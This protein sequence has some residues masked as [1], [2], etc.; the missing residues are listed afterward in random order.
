ML[1]LIFISSGLFLGWSLGA[2]DAANIF[3][4]AVGSRMLSFRRAAIIASTF[5]ILGAVF[6]GKGGAETLNELGTVDALGGSFTVTLC[7]AF[8]VYV[9]TKRRL[10]VSTSQAIVGAI[11]GWTMFTG[12]STDLAVLRKIVITWISGPVLG[13]VFAAGL[14]ILLRWVLRKAKIHVIKL[15]TY[16]RTALILVGAFGA[17]SLGAN[18]IANVMG[19]FVSS[20]PNI[21]LDF[22]INRLDGVQLLFLLGGIAIA[23]GIFTYGQRVMQTVGNDILSL[24]PEAAIVVVLAQALVLFLFSSTAFSELVAKTGLPPFP[25]VPV[26]STQVVIGSV[27]GIGLVKG[28][29]EIKLKALGGVAMGWIA[30]PVIAGILTFFMLFF[31]QNV[32][33][34]QITKG[35][36]VS[37]VTEEAGLP[38]RT[39]DMVVYGLLILLAVTILALIL[40]V[41]RQQKL[42]WK[43]TNELLVQQN[44]NYLVRQSLHEME[45]KTIQR[46]KDELNA[47]LENKRKEFI[48]IALNLTEQRTFLEQILDEIDR[49]RKVSDRTEAEILFRQLSAKIRQ[50][51]SFTTEKENFY[52]Q[53][54]QVHKDFQ[55]KLTAGF[56]H[57][58]LQ[59]K[60]LA[61]LIRLNLSTKEIATLLNIS[62]KSVEV[63]RYRLKKKLNLKQ[64]DNLAQFIN[65]L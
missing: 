4:S 25:L 12:H 28:V 33:D 22:G 52:S 41:F 30:T 54:E 48:D 9:M 27:L 32:F 57:L 65:N 23:V 5:V 15:D 60:H 26:S 55:M 21:V 18:N 7:A 42:R 40:I 17:Y 35:I 56:P 47:R 3:G 61:M 13:M 63:T 8:T 11:I 1:L 58:T 29:R 43:T 64:D 45:V 6:Q 62:P 50:R 39:V 36:P 14:Y 2:N 53:I 46:Q 59:E 38:A 49:I 37:D 34:L 31:M 24:N 44:Q 10:P 51:M 16:I 20:A 19:V